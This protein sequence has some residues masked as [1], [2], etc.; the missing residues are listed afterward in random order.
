MPYVPP[1]RLCT[2]LLPGHRT[3]WVQEAHVIFEPGGSWRARKGSLIAADGDS[4]TIRFAGKREPERF[5]Y[6]D[7][8][9]LLAIARWLPTAVWLNDEYCLLRIGKNY[10]SVQPVTG[11]P[12]TP[13]AVE[14]PPRDGSSESEPFWTQ[15]F[16]GPAED[17]VP[18]PGDP[19]AD[20]VADAVSA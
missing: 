7:P 6:H 3:H 2:S 12:P 18:M 4:L 10:L 14:E 8:D 1:Q 15:R 5:Y 11:G 13:C 9:R 17:S 16:R 19:P 20:S